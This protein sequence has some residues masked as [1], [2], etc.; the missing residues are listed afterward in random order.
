MDRSKF[1][2]HFSLNSKLTL[3]TLNFAFKLLIPE[4]NIV[5][6]NYLLFFHFFCF[7]GNDINHSPFRR[8]SNEK[9]Q[10]DGSSQ[11]GWISYRKDNK[12]NSTKGSCFSAMNCLRSNTSSSSDSSWSS[13]SWK[14]NEVDGMSRYPSPSSSYCNTTSTKSTSLPSNGSGSDTVSANSSFDYSFTSTRSPF[15]SFSSSSS[16]NSDEKFKQ[17]FYA[18]HSVFLSNLRADVD[19]S[20]SSLS[21]DFD[22]FYTNDKYKK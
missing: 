10:H 21:S 17:H 12:A 15:S 6:K 18:S 5:K 13:M 1:Y 4:Y 22:N 11:N 3:L 8:P 16:R 20:C 14:S 9:G 2:F 19:S 7:E